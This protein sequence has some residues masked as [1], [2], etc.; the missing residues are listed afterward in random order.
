PKVGPA[1]IV[2]SMFYNRPM[3]AL[4]PTDPDEILK[5]RATVSRPKGRFEAVQA[6]R[7]SD[8]WDIPEE[9]RLVRTEVAIERPR[10]VI[11][12]NTSPDV[13]FDR[14]INPYR[15]CE[16][17]CIYCFARPFHSYLGLS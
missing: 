2:R 4:P 5:A 8:G 11:A 13:P 6:V 7:E 17:G 14:S 16:H 9:Q 1:S 10:S 3:S 12:R 15:G